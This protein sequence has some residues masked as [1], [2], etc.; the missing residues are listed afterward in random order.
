M[1]V[2]VYARFN[3]CRVY[4]SSEIQLNARADAKKKKK[5]KKKKI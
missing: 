5:K 1:C 2:E 4:V 3:D